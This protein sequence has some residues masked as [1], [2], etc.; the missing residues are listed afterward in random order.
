MW[1]FQNAAWLQSFAS[2]SLPFF[3]EFTLTSSS[4]SH[5]RYS[6]HWKYTDSFTKEKLKKVTFPHSQSFVQISSALN[7]WPS[8][9]VT[10]Q[11]VGWHLSGGGM[12]TSRIRT[13]VCP[14]SLETNSSYSGLPASACLGGCATQ[15]RKR[16]RQPLQLMERWTQ[17]RKPSLF[18][19]GAR[20]AEKGSWKTRASGRKQPNPSTSP[21]SLKR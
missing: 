16:V 7:K 17:V 2:L 20:P 12:V 15:I 5:I 18:Q 8:W 9:P 13:K 14:A 4:V 6:R 19:K 3:N 21:S 11:G 10:A 1:L